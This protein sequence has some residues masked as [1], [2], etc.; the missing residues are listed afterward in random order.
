[1]KYI[2]LFVL[3]FAIVSF[4]ACK[5]NSDNSDV[6]DTE[7]TT[8]DEDGNIIYPDGTYCADVEYYNPD[9]GTRNTYSL[10]VEVE[11][12]EVTVIQWTNGGWLDSSHFSPEELDSS[13]S[14]S[15]TTFDG[16]QYD[17][18]ITGPECTFTD[19]NRVSDDEEEVKCPECGGVK[20]EFDDYC[21][22]CERKFKCP[23]CGGKKYKYDDV[24]DEC[25][26]KAEHTC[27][28]CGQHDSFMFSTDDLCSDCKRKEEDKKREEE[29]DQ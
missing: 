12:N 5:K 21:S 8:T 10:N 22:S 29:E 27:K 17:I 4:T 23:E 16:K 11:N 3:F 1:M 20:S 25:K 9:T 19:N 7:L 15:F 14:C 6:S 28:R 24:C 2:K 13:G 26:D 18:Q